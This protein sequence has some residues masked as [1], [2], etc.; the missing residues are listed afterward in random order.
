MTRNARRFAV[1][2]PDLAAGRLVRGGGAIE[3]CPSSV[4]EGLSL[5][6]TLLPK[7]LYMSMP[8][9]AAATAGKRRA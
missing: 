9:K 3:Q 5:I 7:P 2:S 8:A 1:L 4:R 6:T